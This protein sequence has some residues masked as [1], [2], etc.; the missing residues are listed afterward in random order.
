M[1]TRS[2]LKD[3]AKNVLRMH[4]GKAFIVSL[5]LL[6]VGASTR[7]G[8]NHG[9]DANQQATNYRYYIQENIS[10]K[11]IMMITLVILGLVLLRILVGVILEVGARKFFLEISKENHN[12]GIGE[13]LGFGF[14]N[15]RY[16]NIV[17]AMLLKEV[18]IFLWALLLIIPGI[19]KSYSYAMVPYILAENPDIQA[20]EA[21]L[22]SKQMTDGHKLDMFILDLS[23]IGWYILGGLLF[24]IG[25][26][27]VN[28][29]Y[30]ATHAQLYMTLSNN[31]YR[32]TTNDEGHYENYDKRES[33]KNWDSY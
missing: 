13:G 6:F 22:L 28:P 9:R 32:G 30:D 15:Q 7:S 10:L 33:E 2:E 27:F 5:V 19:V 23:F 11:L 14:K 3:R 1:W 16:G 20:R 17:R 26:I 21:I 12:Y 18:L 25:V 24:G 29:Y 8:G 31:S 4:Y